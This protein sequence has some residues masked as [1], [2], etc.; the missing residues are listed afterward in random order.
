MDLEGAAPKDLRYKKKQHY[1]LIMENLSRQHFPPGQ[2]RREGSTEHG[3]EE[4]LILV[5][6]LEGFS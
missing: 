4:G 2:K 3:D 5:V 6:G 1:L